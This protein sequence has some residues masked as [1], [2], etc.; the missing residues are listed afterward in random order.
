VGV[1]LDANL[2][3][4]TNFLK[5]KPLTWPSLFEEGGLESRLGSEMGI[6]TLPTMILIDKNGKVVRNNISAAELDKELGKLLK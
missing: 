3:L 5:A 6:L 4:A 1:N 2:G